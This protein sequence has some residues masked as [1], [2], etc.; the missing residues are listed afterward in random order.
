MTTSSRKKIELYDNQGCFACGTANPDGIQLKFSLDPNEEL[1]S[2][3]KAEK[4]FQG[5]DGILHGGVM[6]LLLDEMMVNLAWIKGFHAVSADLQIRLKKPVRTGETIKLRSRIV[7]EEK[8]LVK[9]EAEALLL[10]GT[11]VAEA[12]AVCVKLRTPAKAAYTRMQ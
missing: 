11:R 12:R 8:K 1:V 2:E 9:T 3:F 6:A 7:C 5:F 4:R 10:D